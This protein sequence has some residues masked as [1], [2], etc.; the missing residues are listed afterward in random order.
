MTA[1]TKAY[2][3]ALAVTIAFGVGVVM[4]ASHWEPLLGG[5][6]GVLSSWLCAALLEDY[7]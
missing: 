5:V 2:L 7:F 3:V 4:L 6:A 1:L